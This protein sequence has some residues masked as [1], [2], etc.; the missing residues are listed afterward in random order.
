[1]PLPETIRVKVS[2]E[3][4]GYMSLTPVVVRDMPLRELVELMLGFT[5]KDAARIQELLRRGTL[6][7][8]GS[9]FRW[10]GWETERGEVEALLAAFPDSDPGRPFSARH[11]IHA[12]L[13]GPACQ[14][15]ISREAGTSRRFLRR[16][17][18]WDALLEAAEAGVPRYLEYS[19][20]HRADCFRL[21]L[22]AGAA[23]VLR[24]EARLLR[25]SSLE[26]QV[27][28][29]AIEAVDFYVARES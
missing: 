15:E 13:R 10:A 4:A 14:I 6:V 23:G 22:P 17:T 12:V 20:K 11:A 8:E 1:M 5:G 2:S 19:H 27:R 16:R 28:N 24:R 7:S 3:S 29:A 25:Y 9:R 18:F 21:E 26:H